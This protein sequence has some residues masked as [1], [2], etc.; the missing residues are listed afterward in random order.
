MKYMFSVAS[1]ACSGFCCSSG[2]VKQ[3]ACA[4]VV[5]ADSAVL[6]VCTACI[7]VLLQQ[8]QSVKLVPSSRY[9]NMFS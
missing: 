8:S 2:G 3:F 1:A 6:A 9:S 4:T 7:A 5:V